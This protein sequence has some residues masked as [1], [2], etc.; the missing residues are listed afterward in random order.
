MR[1]YLRMRE[2]EVIEYERAREQN[3]GKRS[4]PRIDWSWSEAADVYAGAEAEPGPRI[5][6]GR[7]YSYTYAWLFPHVML[8]HVLSV[9][10]GIALLVAARAGTL[11][12]GSWQW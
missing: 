1:Y 2:I 4:S 3:G 12:S 5:Q 7:R 6:D 11:G 10:A 8:P 9:L